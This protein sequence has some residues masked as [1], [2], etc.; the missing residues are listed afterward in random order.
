[1]ANPHPIA[2]LYP[3]EPYHPKNAI[4]SA[5]QG[6]GVGAAAGLIAAAV[7]NSLAKTSVGAGGVFSRHGATVATMSTCRP[8]RW[9]E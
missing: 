8:M 1:M 2:K 3:E 7:Q 6:A 5:V 9:K 4:T